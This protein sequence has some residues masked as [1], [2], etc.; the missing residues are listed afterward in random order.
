MTSDRNGDAYEQTKVKN[1]Y[2]QWTY[3][4]STKLLKLLAASVNTNDI[5]RKEK[6]TCAIL[7]AL[8]ADFHTNKDYNHVINK[9][10]NWKQRLELTKDLDASGI[11]WDPEKKKFVGSDEKWA[12]LRK[13]NPKAA[14]LR[15][16][17]FEDYE[18]LKLVVSHYYPGWR[19]AT[20]LRPPATPNI[21]RKKDTTD[22]EGTT[23]LITSPSPRT[24][25]T[26]LSSS[27]PSSSSISNQ[28]K[29]KAA[30]IETPEGPPKAGTEKTAK[31]ITRVRESLHEVTVTADF[32]NPTQ[33][34]DSKLLNA[35]DR[36]MEEMKW[37]AYEVF[38]NATMKEAFLRMP[39]DERIRFLLFK[40]KQATGGKH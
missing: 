10:K 39:D 23:A 29:R 25:D 3:N 12:E 15:H 20:S 1:A 24:N 5:T 37:S 9:L 40:L 19:D 13:F 30:A 6:I 17:V 11:V 26:P 27:A 22:V 16:K 36:V 28:R 35:V 33:H 32:D 4:E 14:S 7:P 21:E 31:N 38:T 18:L 34:N 8:N 2:E